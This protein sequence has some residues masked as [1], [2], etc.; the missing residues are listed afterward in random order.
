MHILHI[1]SQ[2]EW[3]A[4]QVAGD[5]RRST[6]DASLAEVGF[7]HCCTEDQLAGV[8]TRFYAD[9]PLDG[10]VLLIVDVEAC[11][12]AGSRV[13]WEGNSDLFPHV[14]GP[15]PLSAVVDTRALTR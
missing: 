9:D 15:I 10:R 11:E 3:A 7:I 8:L 13:T 4:A 14:Y 6:A 12:S 2:T 5:Y 1:A